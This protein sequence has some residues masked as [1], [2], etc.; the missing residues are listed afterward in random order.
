MSALLL[1]PLQLSNLVVDVE[2]SEGSKVE[3]TNPVNDIVGRHLV[4]EEDDDDTYLSEYTEYDDDNGE[5]EIWW[6]DIPVL[7]YKLEEMTPVELQNLMEHDC[8][9]CL[10]EMKRADCVTTSCNH[11][12]CVTC[13]EKYKNPTCPCCRQMVM[14]L[15]KYTLK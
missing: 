14:S 12:F 4:F 1:T 13:Y 8:P 5:E 7:E 11:S 10:E 6:D 2:D 3:L 9:V 15:T